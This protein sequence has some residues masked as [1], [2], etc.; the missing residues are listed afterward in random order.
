MMDIISEFSSNLAHKD[1]MMKGL[2]LRLW[3]QLLREIC[4]RGKG[5]NMDHHNQM[6]R[7][8]SFIAANL[9]RELSLDEIADSVHLSKFYLSHLFKNF[10]SMS[11]ISYHKLARINHAKKML[12]LT[13][14][15][16]SEASESLGFSSIHA[17]SRVFKSVE[18]VSPSQYRKYFE[19]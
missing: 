14:L 5:V 17:F 18:G 13:D 19:A 8:K 7:V 4:W 9:D 3:A 10:F 11:P 2:M 16:I 15:S 6:Y 1:I 12:Q